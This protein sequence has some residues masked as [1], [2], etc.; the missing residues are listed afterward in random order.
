MCCLSVHPS[1]KSHTTSPSAYLLAS[2][3]PRV[4]PL[5]ERPQPA[6]ALT[7]PL[8]RPGASAGA[9]GRQDE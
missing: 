5:A 9:Q 1:V 2:P 3:G 8:G 7:T 4:W 6:R